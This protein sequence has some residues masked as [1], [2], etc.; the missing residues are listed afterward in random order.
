MQFQIDRVSQQ[1]ETPLPV[2]PR[3]TGNGEMGG[4][5]EG[6]PGGGCL[7]GDNLGDG[8][9]QSICRDKNDHSQIFASW[10]EVG[11]VDE[12]IKITP[13]N[14][15]PNIPS[16]CNFTINAASP[17]K[18]IELLE[19]DPSEKLL[20][21]PPP[22][23]SEKPYYNNRLDKLCEVYQNIPTTPATP[24][25]PSPAPAQ[26]P[27]AKPSGARGVFNFIFPA[28]VHAGLPAGGFATGICNIDTIKNMTNKDFINGVK[29]TPRL[30]ELNELI[31]RTMQENLEKIKKT[32][33]HRLPQCV[34]YMDVVH[35]PDFYYSR[36]PSTKII[37]NNGKKESQKM[38]IQFHFF[39][40]PQMVCFLIQ[41]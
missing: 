2:D 19:A 33:S 22:G 31:E 15:N 30:F 23:V 20:D 29:N 38:V 21:P 27:E 1:L 34:P 26:Q 18:A 12:I 9:A 25:P 40:V 11:H 41:Q 14:K 8:L 35:V 39:Q 5:L 13:G 7:F 6:L 32:I 24:A 3:S 4:N 36:N 10:L 37:D 28:N 16:E 17:M